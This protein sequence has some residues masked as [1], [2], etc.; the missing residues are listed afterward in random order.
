[1]AE[2][3]TTAAGHPHLKF[4]NVDKTVVKRLIIPGSIGAFTGPASEQPRAS[5]PNPHRRIPVHPRNLRHE[6][7]L[8]GKKPTQ[9]EQSTACSSRWDSAVSLIP[10]AEDGDRSAR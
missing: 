3:V 4:G 5:W 6:R 7:F 8:F 2:V 1:M 9:N 10:L